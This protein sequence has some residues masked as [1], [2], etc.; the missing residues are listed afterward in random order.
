M[1][2]NRPWH[3]PL[4][5]SKGISYHKVY[6]AVK[7]Q[8]DKW[9]LWDKPLKSPFGLLQLKFSPWRKDSHSIS[10]QQTNFQAD[11]GKSGMPLTLLQSF[12]PV[13]CFSGIPKYCNDLPHWCE[14]LWY[15][16]RSR[17]ESSYINFNLCMQY[18]WDFN[19]YFRRRY[20]ICQTL[21]FKLHEMPTE[22]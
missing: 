18:P 12:Y 4:L 21:G 11:L 16:L 19:D 8:H 15:Q 7:H 20:W 1:G 14:D 22:Y 13:I 3:Y 2:H 6:Q 17:T 10:R 5:G 9:Y